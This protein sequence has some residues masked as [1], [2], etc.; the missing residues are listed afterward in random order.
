MKDV[1]A[2]ATTKNAS[3]VATGMGKGMFDKVHILQISGVYPIMN[4]VQGLIIIDYNVCSCSMIDEWI[5]RCNSVNRLQPSLMY[6]E[7][8]ENLD[9]A[10]KGW[11]LIL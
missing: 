5:Q 8:H 10:R 2:F 11:P 3:V 4:H 7:Y 6:L 9:E 1:T